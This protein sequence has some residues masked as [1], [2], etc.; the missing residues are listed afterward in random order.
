MNGLI[1]DWID[2]L[3]Q[4]AVT[5]C[6]VISLANCLED[7]NVSSFMQGSLTLVLMYALLVQTFFVWVSCGFSGVSL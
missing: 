5:L 7:M 1:V 3:A 4:N 2:C 6:I